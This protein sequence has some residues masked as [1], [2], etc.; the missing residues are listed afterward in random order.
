MASSLEEQIAADFLQFDGLETVTFKTRRDEDGTFKTLPTLQALGTRGTKE[1]EMLIGDKGT[2]KR[3]QVFHCLV[4]D[5]DGV[6]TV[7]P[8]PVVIVANAKPRDRIIDSS[9]VTWVIW[10]V[11]KECRDQRYRFICTEAL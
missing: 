2:G 9:S 5:I 11:S 8:G 6:G 4:E 10:V 3:K 1:D 7:D